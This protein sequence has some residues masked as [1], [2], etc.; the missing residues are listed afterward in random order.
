MLPVTYLYDIENKID[1]Y[2]LLIASAILDDK[3]TYILLSVTGCV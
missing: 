1:K 3:D 2:I